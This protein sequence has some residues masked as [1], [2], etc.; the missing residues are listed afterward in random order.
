MNLVVPLRGTPRHMNPGP[1][2]ALR[3]TRGYSKVTATRSKSCAMQDGMLSFFTVRQRS[4]LPVRRKDR[5]EGLLRY[6]DLADLFHFRLALLLLF[7][8]LLLARHVTGVAVGRHI[9]AVGLDRRAGGSGR[10]KM[11][12]VVKVFVAA[13]G[14]L[15]FAQPAQGNKSQVVK[16][17]AVG[18][19]V[20]YRH[21]RKAGDVVV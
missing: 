4:L 21:V 18:K 8:E 20:T 13:G 7:E 11:L 16:L 1:R 12:Q 6:L 15:Q 2:V 5:N 3:S 19:D 10:G 9:L 17:D 14:L